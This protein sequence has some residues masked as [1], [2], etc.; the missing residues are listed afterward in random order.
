MTA[1]GLGA[2]V[3]A[4]AVAAFPQPSRTALL[5]LVCGVAFELALVGFALS[6]T[7]PIAVVLLVLAG[8]LSSAFAALN[9][10][11]V[12]GNT[13][14]HLYGR[15]ASEYMMTFA[16]VPIGSLPLAW[17]SDLVGTPVAVVAAGS[18]VVV[19]LV[20]IGLLHRPYW[21]VR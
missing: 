20:C 8:V 6:P 1:T 16:M 11:L 5:Q 18:L 14:T 9:N 4:V 10:T 17:L 3:G 13:G 21:R 19:A 15:V 7:F 12:I 2:I